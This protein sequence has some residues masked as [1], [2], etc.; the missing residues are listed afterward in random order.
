MFENDWA[1]LKV[2]MRIALKERF[3]FVYTLLV[4]TFMVFINKNQDFQDNESLYI[5]WS[6]I[7]VTTVFNGFLINIIRLREGGFFKTLSYLI[8]SRYSI[9]LANLLVQFFV[10]QVEIFLFNIVVTVFIT[11]VSAATFLHGFLVSFLA[12]LLSSSMMSGLMLLKIK[13]VYFNYLIAIFFILGIALLGIHPYGIWNY[14]LTLV[15]PFQLIYGLY[16]VHCNSTFYSIFISLCVVGYLIMGGM[17]F[18]GMSV[19]SR[20]K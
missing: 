17:I 15:N 8:G 2:Q 7:V 6:Y 13:Q 3:Y 20:L 16:A 5:Y 14:F 4:P 19:K 12:T 1:M 18:K 11:H 10:I 9:V